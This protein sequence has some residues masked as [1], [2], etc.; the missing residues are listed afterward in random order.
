MSLS[1]H[2]TMKQHKTVLQEANLKTTNAR[3]SVLSFLDSAK[4]PLSADEIFDHLKLEHEEADKATIYRILDTFYK[5]GLVNRLEF[6]EGK[7]RYELTGEDHHHLICERCG[8]V[9]DISDCN[10]HI[11][12]KEIGEKKQFLVTRHSLEFFGVCSICQQ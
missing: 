5:K 12:E 4:T 2:N 10:I 11:L 8:A 3:L 9:E 7:Y 1:P 6:S